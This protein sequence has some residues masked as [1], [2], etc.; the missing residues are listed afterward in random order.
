ML[1]TLP[2]S[3]CLARSTICGRSW[4]KSCTA[5]LAACTITSAPAAMTTMIASTSS[6]E[7]TRRLQP[8]RRSIPV[9]NGERTATP[10][11]ETKMTSRTLLIDAIEARRR[12]RWLPTGSSGSRSRRRSRGGRLRSTSP[13]ELLSARSSS[14]SVAGAPA[15]AATARVPLPPRCA[16]YVSVSRYVSIGC[17]RSPARAAARRAA[18]SGRT[19]RPSP[20]SPSG[21][22]DEATATAVT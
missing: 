20:R 2:R 14:P 6:V 13:P 18:A 4:L 16:A 9:A 11:P 3:L 1:R 15:A 10:K 8:S 17:V 21:R 19:R 5:P 22:R 7:H 12:R